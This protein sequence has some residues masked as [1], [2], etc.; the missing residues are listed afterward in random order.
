MEAVGVDDGSELIM[1]NISGLERSEGVG[2]F[3]SNIYI[4]PQV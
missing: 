1:P 4:D 3:L 2:E